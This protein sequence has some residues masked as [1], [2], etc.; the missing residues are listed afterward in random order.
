MPSTLLLPLPLPADEVHIGSFVL[1]PTDPT[2]DY[3]NPLE[4]DPDRKPSVLR[5]DVIDFTNTIRDAGSKEVKVV[6]TDYFST[7]ID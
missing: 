4:K 6:L 1:N 2:Q 5:T 3:F 7:A